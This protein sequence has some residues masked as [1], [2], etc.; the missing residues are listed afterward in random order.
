MDSEEREAKRSAKALRQGNPWSRNAEEAQ[1]SLFSLSEPGT[2]EALEN[3]VIE[4]RRKKRKDRG[5]T[6]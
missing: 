5:N 4:K 1:P 3:V 6:G 2:R